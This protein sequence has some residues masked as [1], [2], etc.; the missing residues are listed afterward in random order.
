VLIFWKFCYNEYYEK[1]KIAYKNVFATTPPPVPTNTPKTAKALYDL[2]DSRVNN[3]ACPIL[4][5]TAGSC[6][7][8][9]STSGSLI[10][11]SATTLDANYNPTILWDSTSDT[12]NTITGANSVPP[13]M[14]NISSTSGNLTINDSN[15]Q[16][17]WQSNS[18]GIA[19]FTLKLT[20]GCKLVLNDSEANTL[21]SSP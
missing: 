10:I 14:M 16:I 8:Q 19:P 5:S 15:N 7:A 2:C 1:A 11:L 13:Y 4:Q 6:Y 12:K 20:P 17:M 3:G 18:D 9:S 21:W